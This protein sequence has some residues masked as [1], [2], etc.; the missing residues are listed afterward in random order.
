MQQQAAS[1]QLCLR[2][3]ACSIELFSCAI[4]CPYKDGET[5]EA[6]AP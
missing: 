1:Q 6:V 3:A 4:V 5:W 2:L